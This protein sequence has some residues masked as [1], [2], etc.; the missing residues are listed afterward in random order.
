MPIDPVAAG[1]LS[2]N[3]RGFCPHPLRSNTTARR[4]RAN[5]MCD[6]GG[7][8][9]EVWGR[10]GVQRPGPVGSKGVSFRNTPLLRHPNRARQAVDSTVSTK[11]STG[12]A[13]QAL[14]RLGAWRGATSF[15]QA[16]ARRFAEEEQREATAPWQA[17]CLYKASG[18]VRNCTNKG[19]SS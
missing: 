14:C 10:L 3:A 15:L 9:D 16:H 13:S 12:A 7:R 2:R 6:G 17:T 19:E 4:R 8:G 18:S 1:S 5:V 11:A